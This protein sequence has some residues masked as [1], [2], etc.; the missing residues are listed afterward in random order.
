MSRNDQVDPGWAAA[1]IV[2]AVVAVVSLPALVLA[3]PLL[4]LAKRQRLVVLALAV[5]GLG[6]T[7]VLSSNITSE[8]EAALAATRRVGGFWEYPE[9]SL[10]AAWPH[11]RSWWLMALG[12]AP[13]IASVIELFRRRSV[14][15]LREREERR[16]DLARRRRERRARRKVGAPEP[17]RRPDGFEIGRH[18][19]GDKLLHIRRG[20]V[21][22]PLARLEKTLLVI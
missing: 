3:V 6:I 2:G 7:A 4:A 14:E 22:M 9:Q 15:E 19:E 5:A 8:M 1:L 10:E 13:A 16:T 12:M 11:V 20:R 18:V 21:V 17:P